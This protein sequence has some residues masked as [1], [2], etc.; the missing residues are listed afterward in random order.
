M[1]LL[2]FVTFLAL[3]TIPQA[4]AQEPTQ[5]P[6][7]T[8]TLPPGL[9]R[10]LNDYEEAW[11]KR[12]AAALARLFAEDGFVLPSG[13]A[14]VRGRGAIEMFYKGRGGPLALR[15]IGYGMEG[16]VGYIIGGFARRAGEADLGKFTLTLQ[17]RRDGRWLIV[18]DMDNPN[19]FP[20]TSHP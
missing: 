6:A 7:P 5:T 19:S 12:D 4:V 2:L 20:P 13:H 3:G 11:Q 10:V 17:K 16:A 8:V 18:S 9:A 1:R 14:P 15:A